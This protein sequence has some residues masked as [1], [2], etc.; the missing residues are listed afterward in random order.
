MIATIYKS[1]H[2][3]DIDIDINCFATKL[4]SLVTLLYDPCGCRHHPAIVHHPAQY[5]P[6]CDDY[7]PRPDLYAIRSRLCGLSTDSRRPGRLGS[8]PASGAHGQ[9]QAGK[10]MGPSNLSFDHGPSAINM[11]LIA[12]LEMLFVYR[13]TLTI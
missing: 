1:T 13:S 8:G 5:G 12:L 7:Q 9:L 4:V 10:P 11:S 6:R 2:A 3:M